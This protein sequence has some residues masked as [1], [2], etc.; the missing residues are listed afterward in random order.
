M[1]KSIPNYALKENL[2]KSKYI[3][4]YQIHLRNTDATKL[5]MNEPRLLHYQHKIIPK[6]QHVLKICIS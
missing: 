6:V 1:I 2:W 5:S 4:E 3:D